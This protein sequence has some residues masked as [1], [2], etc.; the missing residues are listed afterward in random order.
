M[1]RSRNVISLLEK[2]FPR[3]V[4]RWC[5]DFYLFIWAFKCFHQIDLPLVYLLF[6]LFHPPFQRQIHPS[7]LF[8]SI[9]L[10]FHVPPFFY[11]FTHSAIQSSI[12]L[13]IHP[14]LHLS[15]Y[16]SILLFIPPFLYFVQPL[17]LFLACLP[18][19][20]AS[21]APINARE[22]QGFCGGN[23]FQVFLKRSPGGRT[24]L[25]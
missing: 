9:H 18:E 3:N 4:W 7:I 16:S 6:I 8:P 11:S 23:K 2:R 1:K 21:I 12:P 17:K 22:I 5:I 13:F 15:I 14:S 19:T 20:A 10:S 24:C 25:H